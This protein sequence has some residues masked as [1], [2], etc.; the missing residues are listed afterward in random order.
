LVHRSVLE[1]RDRVPDY[2]PV[3][4]PATYT[5]ENTPLAPDPD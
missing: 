5:I 1:R 3:N 2:K 4:L